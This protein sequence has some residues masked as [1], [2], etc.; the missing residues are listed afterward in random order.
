ML[1]CTPVL[2]LLSLSFRVGKF[3]K[4]ATNKEALLP[5]SER[6]KSALYAC[7]F[8]SSLPSGGEVQEGGPHAGALPPVDAGADL[9]VAHAAHLQH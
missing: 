9:P 7:S 4:E 1:Y 8:F 5:G 6:I 2:F 3:K